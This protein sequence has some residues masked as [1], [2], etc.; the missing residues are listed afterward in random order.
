MIFTPESLAPAL[1][2]GRNALNWT[3]QEMAEKSG[4]SMPT[5]ARTETSN[6]PK[7][8]TVLA[9]FRVMAEHGV[10]FKWQEQGFAMTVNFLQKQLTTID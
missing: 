1:R 8:E 4:V 10:S 5:I 3:Q 7:M 6:N 2:A 9:L